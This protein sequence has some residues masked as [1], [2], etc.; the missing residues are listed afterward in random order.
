VSFSHSLIVVT[1]KAITGL[2]CRI[3]D[4]EL[5]RIPQQGPL[6]IY[7]NHVNILE[8]P[9]I[10]THLQP[11]RVHGILLAERWNIPILRWMLSVTETSPLHRAEADIDAIRLGLE[12]LGKG[13]TI[14]ISP[15]GTRS[16]DG[17]LQPAHPGVVLLAL[18]SHA[19]LLPVAYYGAENWQE[20]LSHLRRT[21]FHV[22][23]GQA[24]HLDDYGERVTHT[25][26]QRMIEEMMFQL[27]SLLPA[28]NRGYYSDLS[29]ADKKYIDL[30]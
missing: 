10:Y 29:K 17:K 27:A 3:D 19:P 15:E 30:G 6:I 11:R 9:I 12:V 2:I 16:H 28:E 1:L 7:T 20:N 8:I 24:F 23:V 4:Q 14:I 25:V 5:E 21:D 26:R 22:R 13:R 18:H